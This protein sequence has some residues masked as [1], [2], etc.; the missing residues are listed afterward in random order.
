MRESAV[1]ERE[2]EPRARER[3]RARAREIAACTGDRQSRS[4]EPPELERSARERDRESAQSPAPP[5]TI[6]PSASRAAG[7]PPCCWSSR[8]A[9]PSFYS[10]L[11]RPPTRQHAPR[12]HRRRRHA[13]H[14]GDPRHPPGLRRPPW[15][16]SPSTS[17]SSNSSC[18]APYSLSTCSIFSPSLYLLLSFVRFVDL[19]LSKQHPPRRFVSTR[20]LGPVPCERQCTGTGAA[21]LD[22][23]FG[24][25]NQRISL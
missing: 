6:A 4:S 16:C 9:S 2:R 7:R 13:R 5:V 18:T 1:R 15:A 23:S 21:P 8:P 3:G 17:S 22:P 12:A 14:R 24:P 11:P 20:V 19:L 10:L 25:S